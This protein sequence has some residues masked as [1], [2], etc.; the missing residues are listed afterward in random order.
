MLLLF[1]VLALAAVP[2]GQTSQ[3]SPEYLV[4]PQDRLS[5]TVVDEPTLT[6]IVTVGSDG[7][8]DYPFIGQVKAVGLKLRAIQQDIAARLGEKY[9]RNPQVSI[10][11]ESYRSQVVYV[12]GQ[13]RTP[14]AVTLMG[15]ISLTE[16]L[17]KA[18]SPTPDAGA[19][20]EINRRPRTGD[21]AAQGAKPAAERVTMVDLQSG[22][23][24]NIFLGDGDT[25]FV[26]KAEMFFVTGYVKNGGPFLHEAGMTVSKAISMAGGVTEK[27]SRGRIRITRLSNG[28]QVIIKDVKMDDLVFPGDSV[29]VLSR[30][31]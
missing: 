8:F 12:W 14:G 19:Y 22:R 25:V 10:E 30:L 3:S 9:L 4:G 29:E 27:G 23:A 17:A 18:G 16:A 2:A 26:P 31:W 13:V 11:V 5:I 21:A 28:K 1:L 20:I 7:T 15:N 24:Q 6:K